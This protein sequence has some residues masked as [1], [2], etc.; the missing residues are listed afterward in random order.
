MPGRTFRPVHEI[1]RLARQLNAR[2][3]KMKKF[4][5]LIVAG[6]AA[7]ASPAAAQTVSGS[8]TLTGTVGAKC[9][10]LPGSG[11]SFSDA[12]DFLALDKADGTLRTGLATDFGTKSFTVKCNSANPL[13]TIQASSLAT[14]ATAPTGYDNSIDYTA[15]LD[16]DTTAGVGAGTVSDSSA[17]AGSTSASA[18]APLANA[19]N[20]V[21][22]TTSGYATNTATDILVAGTYNGLILITIAPN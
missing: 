2:K 10:V 22:V 14:A 13:L 20:N 15:K 1:R 8:I 3:E 7:F 12:V 4:A 9:F 5:M 21:R 18:G 17:V 16:V 11:S 6:A 19:A